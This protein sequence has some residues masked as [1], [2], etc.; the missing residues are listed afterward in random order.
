MGQA[1]RFATLN[2]HFHLYGSIIF[3]FLFLSSVI[4]KTEAGATI[5]EEISIPF[6]SL[7]LLKVNST[8]GLLMALLHVSKY[9]IKKAIIFLCFYTF[10]SSVTDSF[11]FIFNIFFIYFAK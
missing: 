9:I 7:L 1:I 8:Q 11:F 2:G 4:L 5:Q 3:L 10:F 6:Y